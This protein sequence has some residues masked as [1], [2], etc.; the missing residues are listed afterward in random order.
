MFRVAQSQQIVF[1][2]GSMDLVPKSIANRTHN[3]GNVC[4][5]ISPCHFSVR[6]LCGKSFLEKAARGKSWKI[7]PCENYTIDGATRGHRIDDILF[8]NRERIFD[9]YE[10]L[11][12]FTRI[13][14]HFYF[15]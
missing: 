13:E 8:I 12:E 15:N 1:H 10:K 11:N 4:T 3:G 7:H 14:I 2:I 9:A 6:L 5:H